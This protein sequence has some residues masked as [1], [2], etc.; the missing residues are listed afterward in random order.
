MRRAR[1]SLFLVGMLSVL[2][3][4]LET[5]MEILADSMELAPDVRAALLRREDFY[6]AVLGLVESYEQGW[7]D[8][9]DA[10]AA[11]VGVGPVTLAPMYL[12]ALAWATAQQGD[13][14]ARAAR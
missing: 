8:Q 10:L 2:D 4:L 7:W 3:Q 6:G 13:V 11:A 12:E 1:G 14:E 5:P 9:V